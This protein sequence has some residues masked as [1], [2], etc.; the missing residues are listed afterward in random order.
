[1][2]TPT[3]PAFPDQLR[4]ITPPT[5]EP[6]KSQDVLNFIFDKQTHF[7]DGE[8]IEICDLCKELNEEEHNNRKFSEVMAKNAFTDE[9]PKTIT[10]SL[11]DV[12]LFNKHAQEIDKCR[13]ELKEFLVHCKTTIA[14]P[15][16]DSIVHFKNESRK[17]AV[18]LKSFSMRRKY[19]LEQSRKYFQ[20]A[21]PEIIKDLV[22]TSFNM[23]NVR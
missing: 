5:A 8:Y 6:S 23:S 7:T 14:Q 21:D 19:H 11:R 20:N 13:E 17:M 15:R 16:M 22:S 9:D 4:V 2:M 18:F 12:Y 1:M 3:T 10:E